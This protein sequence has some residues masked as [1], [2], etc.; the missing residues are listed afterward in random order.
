MDFFLKETSILVFAQVAKVKGM[1]PDAIWYLPAY[2]TYAKIMVHAHDH[3]WRFYGNCQTLP[4]LKLVSAIFCQ[5][6]IFSPNC[7]PAKTMK[8]IF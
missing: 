2:M 4:S 5:I 7:S 8:S 6:F 1:T 3:V